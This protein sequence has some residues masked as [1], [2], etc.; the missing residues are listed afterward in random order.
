MFTVTSV[1]KSLNLSLYRSS[2]VIPLYRRYTD[3]Y[4]TFLPVRSVMYL[5]INLKPYFK[6]TVRLI[7]WRSVYRSF[8]RHRV[9]WHESTASLL[10][11]TFWESTTFL[12]DYYVHFPTLLQQNYV[13]LPLSVIRFLLSNRIY[14]KILYRYVH[15]FIMYMWHLIQWL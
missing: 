10:D 12:A 14:T 15:L 6:G 9:W 5:H 7:L 11:E 1:R 4:L 13:P 8:S 3:I 2:Q